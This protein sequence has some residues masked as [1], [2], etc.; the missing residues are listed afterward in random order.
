MDTFMNNKNKIHTIAGISVF[1]AFAVVVAL[2]CQVIPKIAGFL[3]LDFKDAVIAMASFIYGPISA[4][5]IAFIAAFIEMISFST[6]EWYGFLMNFAS[7][8]TFSLSASLIYKKHRTLNGALTGFTLGIIATTGIMLLLNIAVT[9][10]FLA[11]K[12]WMPSNEA[13]KSYVIDLLPKVLL[14]FNFAKTLLNSALAMMLY[15]PVSNA[16]SHIGIGKKKMGVSF[17]K[18]SVII[19]ITGSIALAVALVILFI[20]A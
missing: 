14:P 13:A 15:K 16:I 20:I 1:S 6:T 4:V 12:G 11:Y 18:N 3:T 8:A 19:L 9:P 2:V 10:F 7:S 5:V 17:N